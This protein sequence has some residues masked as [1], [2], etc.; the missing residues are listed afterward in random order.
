VFHWTVVT[1]TTDA[2]LVGIWTTETHPSFL[3]AAQTNGQFILRYAKHTERFMLVLTFCQMIGWIYLQSLVFLLGSSALLAQL[4]TPRCLNGRLKG[5]SLCVYHKQLW[6]SSVHIHLALMGVLAL[7]V[8][9]G[10][11]CKAGILIC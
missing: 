11:R 4:W 1:T 2:K 9:K 10:A 3:G 7:P 8:L 5:S 6:S